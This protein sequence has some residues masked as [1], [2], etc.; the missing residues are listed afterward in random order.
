MEETRELARSY[1]LTRSAREPHAPPDVIIEQFDVQRSSARERIV[2]A[3]ERAAMGRVEAGAIPGSRFRNIRVAA[4]LSSLRTHRCAFPAYVLAYRY[5]DELYR[6]VISA[7]DSSCIVGSAPYSWW[8]IG[9]TAG[10]VIAVLGAVIGL[11]LAG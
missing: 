6:A 1:E 4:L 2:E 7:Q 8:K 10:A 3:A 11:L 5:R 9:A